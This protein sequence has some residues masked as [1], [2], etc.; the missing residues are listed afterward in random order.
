VRRTCAPFAALIVLAAAPGGAIADDTPAAAP[1]PPA[2]TVEEVEHRVYIAP[3]AWFGG[4]AQALSFDLGRAEVT[5]VLSAPR[6]GGAFMTTGVRVE[7]VAHS[8]SPAAVQGVVYLSGGV[9]TW[10]WWPFGVEAAIGGGRGGSRSYGL[11]QLSWLFVVTSHFEAF[12][13]YQSPV[14]VHA[15]WPEWLPSWIVGVRVGF[16]VAMPRREHV[17]ATRAPAGEAG[18]AGARPP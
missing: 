11:L 17:T 13:T 12:A 1:S 10:E 2:T 7:G 5:S 3:G 15:A 18:P 8:W 9:A 14:G 6:P 4:E 16:D